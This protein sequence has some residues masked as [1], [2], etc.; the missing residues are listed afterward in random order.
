MRSRR[1]VA[2]PGREGKSHVTHDETVPPADEGQSVQLT[3]LWM[4]PIAKLDDKTSFAGGFV[5]FTMSQLSA[6]AYAMTLV[7]YA[8]GVGQIDPGM[9]STPTV[10]HF[11]VVEG[12]IVLVL[13]TE[14]TR[15]RVG[16]TGIIRGVAHGWR[17]D[18]AVKA[19][20]LF[21]TLP[22]TADGI[23]T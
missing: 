16:D 18:A 14:E 15:L 5:P 3:N 12:E 19:R 11:H 2:A 6:D 9:H 21:F 7:D 8:P 10:D 1:I 17:N 20:L 4:G 23:P 22:A 13:E